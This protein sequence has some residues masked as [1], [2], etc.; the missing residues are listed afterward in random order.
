[1]KLLYYPNKALIT[2]AKPVIEARI[3]EIQP[4]IKNMFKIMVENKGIGLS[5]CQVGWPVAL[6]C[7]KTE[8]MKE[9]FINPSVISLPST[10][11]TMIEGCLSYP[12]LWLEKERHNAVMLEYTNLDGDRQKKLFEGLECRVI[13]HEI[14]HLQGESYATR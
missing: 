9:V 4:K 2:V 8:N 12:G 3:H 13:L 1:M 7:L 14:E 10:K 6:F 11:E 5:A